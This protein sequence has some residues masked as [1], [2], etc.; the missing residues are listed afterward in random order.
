MSTELRTTGEPSRESLAG[1]TALGFLSALWS[2]V[3]WA[4]LWLARVTGSATCAFGDSGCGALWDSRFARAVH[5]ASGVPV[6]GWGLAWGLAAAAVPLLL[7][8]LRLE[9][10][11]ATALRTAVR[12]IAA[13]GAASVVVLALV[14]A[15]LGTLCT[16]C[17]V[18]YVL[19]GGY[20]GIALGGWPGAG[21]AALPRAA[22]WA[23]GASALA[24]LMLWPVGR[25]TPR[26]LAAEGR[27][28]I[29]TAAA[30]APGGG[31]IVSRMLAVLNPQQAQTLADSLGLMRAAAAR[32][33]P[34]PR[35]LLGAAQAP[36]RI[37]AWSDVRC[38]HCAELHETLRLLLETYPEKLSVDSRFFPLDG[39][40]NQA[41]DRRGDPTRCLA[42]RAAA[43]FEGRPDA[44]A[45]AGEMFA[46]AET[47]DVARVRAL[48][49]ARLGPQ[50]SCLD[51]AEALARVRA[52]VDA[53]M[54]FGIEGTPLVVLNGRTGTSFPPFLEA[55]VL[56]GG[57]PDHPSFAALPPANPS[58]H[59]H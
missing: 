47:L 25:A 59:L 45:F 58:A 3:L 52:D 11:R 14:S 41:V 44:L 26:S 12:L 40:C 57:N 31:D 39:E 20:A 43:C 17:A 42:A 34:A 38:P 5:D 28:A 29:G 50:A 10:G 54:G 6:A 35:A 56:A 46:E 37:V 4:E 55:M 7:L 8:A 15:G 22:A 1:L 30:P 18:V 49:S 32:P 53:A 13:A 48:A 27:A 36:L 16:G 23:G 33:M 24:L 51:G 2:V 9:P 19:V 21:W